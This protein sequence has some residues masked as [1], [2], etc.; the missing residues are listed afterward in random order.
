M[1]NAADSPQA[2][3]NAQTRPLIGQSEIESSISKL[4]IAD[5]NSILETAE[6]IQTMF[7]G[8]HEA[9]KNEAGPSD[10]ALGHSHDEEGVSASKDETALQKLSK[11]LGT[12]GFPEESLSQDQKYST[13]Q[14]ADM[15]DSILGAL[16]KRIS[17]A[18]SLE[19]EQH[20]GQPPKLTEPQQRDKTANLK[21][22]TISGFGLPPSQD[23]P[24]TKRKP[25]TVLRSRTSHKKGTS[26]SHQRTTA[27]QKPSTA[28]TLP[29]SSFHF[30]GS[31]SLKLAGCNGVPPISFRPISRPHITPVD[32]FNLKRE[33]LGVAY[34]GTVPPSV[35]I[36]M[37]LHSRARKTAG[38]TP[39]STAD[40]NMQTSHA[41]SKHQFVDI[42]VPF[43]EGVD[44]NSRLLP[45]IGGNP[46]LIRPP[47]QYSQSL[48]RQPTAM[49]PQKNINKTKPR[50]ISQREPSRGPPSIA[51][52]GDPNSTLKQD[53]LQTTPSSLMESATVKTQTISLSTL[54]QQPESNHLHSAVHEG[55]NQLALDRHR[56]RKIIDQAAKTVF[57]GTK[58]AD[59][60]KALLEEFS[61]MDHTA[62]SEQRHACLPEIGAKD[63]ISVGDST[64]RSKRRDVQETEL[65]LKNSGKLYLSTHGDRSWRFTTLPNI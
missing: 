10:D 14:M 25:P 52:E 37:R 51:R 12:L 46:N 54:Q 50:A 3:T 30:K 40:S 6:T 57:H 59:E 64:R 18:T 56:E 65:R 22:V 49:S 16:R 23:V 43:V 38:T 36:N 44:A 48:N 27:Y 55:P 15:L 35:L 21:A 58:G 29:A 34:L 1:L 61:V 62:A 26:D 39:F 19:P 32:I 47:S 60:V 33:S 20:S 28:F 53:G 2:N 5:L 17:V 63:L 24:E 4:A 42:H 9:V 41:P 45:F 11:L 8:T 7:T 31:G 13:E